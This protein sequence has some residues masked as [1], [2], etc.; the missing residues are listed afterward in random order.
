M[1][2]LHHVF[3]LT[4]VVSGEHAAVRYLCRQSQGI[5]PHLPGKFHRVARRLFADRH[6]GQAAFH[7]LSQQRRFTQQR[8]ALPRAGSNQQFGQ[9][10][11][12]VGH[13]RNHVG[14]FPLLLHRHLPPHVR[15]AQ[16]KHAARPNGKAEHHRQ[17]R[18]HDLRSLSLFHTI[19]LYTAKL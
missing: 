7:V 3:N 5:L 17:R 2:G 11:L 9:V 8:H 19:P 13:R 16:A 14:H 18:Q 12:D 15:L 1:T 10:D 6:A 4:L